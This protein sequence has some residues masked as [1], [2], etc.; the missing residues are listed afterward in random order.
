MNA[1][2]T[3]KLHDVMFLDKEISLFRNTLLNK[4]PVF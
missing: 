3:V 4:G 2:K 1:S